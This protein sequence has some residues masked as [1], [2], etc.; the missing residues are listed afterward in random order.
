LI[1]QFF[2]QRVLAGASLGRAALEARQRFIERCS[3][4]SPINRKTLAQF[5]LYG[6]PSITPVDVAMAKAVAS[7]GGSKVFAKGL[8]GATALQE[9]G[10]VE[11]A[12]RRATLRAKGEVLKELQ[13]RMSET[14]AGPPKSVEA[15][16]KTYMN[17]LKFTPLP[18][19]VSY[20]V[21]STVTPTIGV[22]SAMSMG[23]TKAVKEKK[24]QTT[25]FHIMFGKPKDGTVTK[26]MSTAKGIGKRGKAKGVAGATPFKPARIKK[27]VALEAKE[28]D[29]KIVSITEAHSK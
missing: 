24:K 27:F 11:R 7:K 5:N 4:L 8:M 28:V 6:D 2:L 3:P 12:D 22:K 13:P 18:N 10:A 26:S 16:L 15:S 17:R 9:A 25:G 21:Q 19:P 23:I 14:K 20:K 29:G 1:C